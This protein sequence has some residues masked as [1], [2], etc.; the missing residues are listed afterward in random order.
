ML[1]LSPSFFAAYTTHRAISYFDSIPRVRAEAEIG[2][3]VE[4]FI[5]GNIPE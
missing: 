5:M 1:I 2:G 4:I 3:G